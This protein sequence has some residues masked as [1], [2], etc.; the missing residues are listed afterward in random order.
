[1]GNEVLT[2]STDITLFSRLWEAFLN[3]MQAALGDFIPVQSKLHDPA[4]ILT[5][6]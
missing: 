2:L 6:R 1:M 3:H 5:Q 4:C